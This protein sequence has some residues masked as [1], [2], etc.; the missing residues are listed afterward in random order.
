VPCVWFQESWSLVGRSQSLSIVASVETFR[1]HSPSNV[2]KISE[3]HDVASCDVNEIHSK[4]SLIVAS[5][6]GITRGMKV[7]IS[8]TQGIQSV[9]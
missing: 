7:K 4:P 1:Q 8:V 9:P 2:N 6:I 5:M 3:L